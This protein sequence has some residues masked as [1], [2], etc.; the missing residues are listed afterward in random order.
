VIGTNKPDALETV[1]C[2]ME[3]LE[4]GATLNPSHPDASAAEKL[5]RERKPSF[6]SWKDW[7]RLDEIEVA[8]GEKE[9]RPRVKFTTVE[10]MQAA[11]GR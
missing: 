5:V 9:G 7:Q 8:Q 3:D 1:N 4:K 2:M 10:E 11:L 6:V